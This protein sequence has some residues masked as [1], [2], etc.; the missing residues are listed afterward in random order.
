MIPAKMKSSSTLK[1]CTRMND[2]PSKIQMSARM[3]ASQT[4]AFI[5]RLSHSAP[6]V[7]WNALRDDALGAT[8]SL[9]ARPGLLAADEAGLDGDTGK[10]N[11]GRH[12]RDFLHGY[13]T[14][15][16]H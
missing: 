2:A 14:T 15:L 13:H 9:T 10:V 1:T 5:G 3:M 11:A 12:I 4:S 7:L 6:A 8:R 16:Y